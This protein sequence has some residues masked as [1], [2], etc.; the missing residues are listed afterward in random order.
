MLLMQQG[1]WK[2]PISIAQLLERK[3][4][5]EFTLLRDKLVV[6]GKCYEVWWYAYRGRNHVLAKMIYYPYT[7][8]FFLLEPGD[9]FSVNDFK[10]Y[11]ET[12]E[13]IKPTVKMYIDATQ[14]QK[15]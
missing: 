5:D 15:R 14:R 1:N 11:L 8:Y 9:L 4:C 6:E 10:V 7:L 12:G 3:G 2:K 13:L